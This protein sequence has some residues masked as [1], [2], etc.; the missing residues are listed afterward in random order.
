[1]R[2]DGWRG[3]GARRLGLGLGLTLLA[4][5]GPSGAQ[6][7]TAPAPGPARP[8]ILLV[9]TDDQRAQGTLGVMPQTR[10]WLARSGTSFSPAYVTTPLCC[11]SR[12]SI[13]SGRYAH[14]HGV[15]YNDPNGPR[16]DHGYSLQRYLWRAGYHTGLLGR[17]MISWPSSE[18]PPFFDEYHRLLFGEPVFGG[19]RLGTWDINGATRVISEYTTTYLGRQAAAFIDHADARADAQPWFL[20]LTPSAPHGPVIPEQRFA[21]APVGPFPANPATAETDLSDKPPFLRRLIAGNPQAVGQGPSV[22][23]GQLRML[24]SVDEMMARVRAALE[25]HGELRNT[26]VVFTSDNGLLWGEHGGLTIKDLPYLPS[27][28][29]PLLVSWPREIPA[30][31]KDHRLAA[32]IDLAPTLLDAAGLQAPQRRMDGRS[33]L[34]DWRREHLVLEYFGLGNRIPPW[35]GIVTRTEQYTE[36]YE[37]TGIFREYYDLRTDPWQISNPFGNATGADDPAAAAVL[38]GKLAQDRLCRRRAC[39]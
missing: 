39:P 16:L 11:P 23:A 7:A 8:N 27:S 24:M 14:N 36:Y 33:L 15:A 18:A 2:F 20:H 35:A 32:N 1:M 29:V 37:P 5:A 17:Y 6:A 10:Q 3:I 19:H 12:A 4:L 34:D 21:N 26:I 13:L 28:E 38:A 9:V 25:A 31:R 22:R 30:G